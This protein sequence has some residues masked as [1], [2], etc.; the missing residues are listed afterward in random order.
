ME[1]AAAQVASS[2]STVIEIVMVIVIIIGSV[3]AAAAIVRQLVMRDALAPAVREIWL[4]YASWIL[5]ALEFAL[6]AD[7]IRTI[8]RPDWNEIGQLAAIAGIRIALSYFLGRDIDEMG[9]SKSE[10]AMSK[11]SAA[12]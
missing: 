2:V 4:H 11:D 8:V 1:V 5:L 9:D 12:S 3:R 10:V 7:I 6:A